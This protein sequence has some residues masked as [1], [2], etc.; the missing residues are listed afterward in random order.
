MIQALNNENDI[1]KLEKEEI[2]LYEGNTHTQT[3]THTMI[4]FG[5]NKRKG[6]LVK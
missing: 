3:F 4:N 5:N 1:K 2:H 6:Y